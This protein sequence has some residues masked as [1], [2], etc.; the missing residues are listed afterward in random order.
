VCVPAFVLVVGTLV[1]A[2]VTPSWVGLCLYE[3]QVS[4]WTVVDLLTFKTNG[5]SP[6]YEGLI[7]FQYIELQLTICLDVR[8]E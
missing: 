1:A 6:E 4:I 2:V 3:I 7:S 8:W 5:Y